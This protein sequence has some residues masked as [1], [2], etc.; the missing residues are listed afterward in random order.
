MVM[1]KV[2]PLI[3]IYLTSGRHKGCPKHVE[4]PR[5]IICSLKKDDPLKLLD[6][7][8]HQAVHPGKFTTL[9]S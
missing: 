1:L 4:V 5:A 7:I 3:P 2:K 9:S 6:D 8:L